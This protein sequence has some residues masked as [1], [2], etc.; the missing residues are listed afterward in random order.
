MERNLISNGRFYNDL[1]NWDYSDSSYLVSDGGKQYGICQI[2]EN[3]YIEQGFSCDYFRKYTISLS[4]KSSV[5]ITEVDVT[6]TIFDKNGNTVTTF[7]PT[8]EADVWTVNQFIIG[9]PASNFKIR[10]RNNVSAPLKI[11][12]VWIWEATTSRADIASFVHWKL[13]AIATD[14][15]LSKTANGDATEGDYTQAIDE[16]MR[17]SG[18]VDPDT[19]EVDVRYINGGSNQE[20]KLADLVFSKMIER[21]KLSYAL[22]VDTKAGDVSKN[23]SQILEGLEKISGAG[24][25]A[26]G[27]ASGSGGDVGTV[28]LIHIADDYEM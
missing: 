25:S 22:K 7:N 6:V 8:C 17:Q 24:G 9:L 28:N 10:I 20:N 18:C 23:L 15:G 16:A 21:A 14:L 27:S 4:I 12:D 13:G 11:D 3:G 26:S 5:E 19:N 1:G 2:E